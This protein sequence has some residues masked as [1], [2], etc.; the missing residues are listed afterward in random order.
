[1][2]HDSSLYSQYLAIQANVSLLI[3]NLSVLAP[4]AAR[5]IL[6]ESDA[7]ADSLTSTPSR[8]R[9]GVR[10]IQGSTLRFS[11]RVPVVLTAVAGQDIVSRSEESDRKA[12]ELS[13]VNY[14]HRMAVDPEA[15]ASILK[16]IV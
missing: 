16:S 2:S 3:C 5:A 4:W 1:M 14:V 13:V 7:D 6:H 12:I 15:V 11:R 10:E 9:R 8:R